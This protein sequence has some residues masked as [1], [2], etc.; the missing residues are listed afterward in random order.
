MVALYDRIPKMAGSMKIA[1]LDLETDPFQFNRMIYPFAAGFYD[2]SVFTSYWGDDCIDRVLELLDK[3][4]EPLTIYAHNGGRFDFFYFLKHIRKNI[5]IV[6]ARIIQAWLGKHELRDSYAIMPFALETYKKTEIDYGKFTRENRENFRDE[7]LAYLSDDC[8]DLWDLCTTFVAEFGPALTIGGA[9]LKQLRKFHQFACGNGE[10]D[11]KFRKDFYFGGR[12]Q[13]FKTGI[14]DD[15]IQVYDVNSMYPY[16][17]GSMLHPVSTGIYRSHKIEENTCFVSVKGRNFGAFCYRNE[18]GMLD[19][20]KE[21]GTFHTTIHEF[22][23]AIETKSFIPD[24]IISTMGFARRESFADF[25]DHF[26]DARTKAKENGDKIRT[27][28]YKFVMNSAYGKFAQNPEN[29]AD[30]FVTETGEFPP[31]YHVCVKSCEEKCRK[32]WTPAYMCENYIIWEKPLY[33]LNWYNIAIGASITGAARSVLLRGI[34]N[35]RRPLYCDTD[36]IICES[37]EHSEF[38]DSKL[39]AWKLEC[40]GTRAA[41]CGK[42]LYAIFDASGKCVKKAHKGA[43]LTGDEILRIAGGATIESCNP[44]PRFQL[45]GGHRFTKRKISRTV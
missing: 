11:T 36:S 19:F 9:S 21:L 12:N 17:M 2:G 39:G 5:R 16:V 41:I 32:K 45:D 28:F 31:D 26:Y 22:N 14:I 18:D 30:W 33:E 37:L 7:I 10:Y 24:K 34:R 1:V 38:S 43:R 40:T 8:R 35:A 27:I 29:Y 3:Y 13:C 20:T 15:N 44:V 42:K 25:V 23:V 4:P 6:N